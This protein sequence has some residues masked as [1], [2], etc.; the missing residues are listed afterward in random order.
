MLRYS[1]KTAMLK[2]KE[3]YL[4]TTPA[5]LHP[6]CEFNTGQVKRPPRL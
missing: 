5:K 2:P 3:R 1:R 4:F 6:K